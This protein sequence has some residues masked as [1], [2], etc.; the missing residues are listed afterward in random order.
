MLRFYTFGRKMATV[1]HHPDH[2]PPQ[3]HQSSLS[4]VVLHSVDFTQKACQH[5]VKLK[6]MKN[7]EVCP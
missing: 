3:P 2:Y 1:G 7:Q 4:S 5:M 6:A